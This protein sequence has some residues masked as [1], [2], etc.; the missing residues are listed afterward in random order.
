MSSS[1]QLAGE[2]GGVKGPADGVSTSGKSPDFD[3]G[4]RRFESYH[5][6]CFPGI[7]VALVLPA[8]TSE[9]EKTPSSRRY[10]GTIVGLAFQP[11]AIA[12]RM[13]ATDHRFPATPEL[14]ERAFALRGEVVHLS[15]LTTDGPRV[16]SIWRAEG[17]ELSDRVVEHIDRWHDVLKLLS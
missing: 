13:D 16:L 11:P 3:S 9:G 8:E 15:V 2:A 17:M 14:I 4:Y 10:T 1:G 5:A 7:A 12:C 6:N